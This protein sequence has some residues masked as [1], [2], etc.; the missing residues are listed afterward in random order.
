MFPTIAVELTKAKRDVEDYLARP[1]IDHRDGRSEDQ[2]ELQLEGIRG[3]YLKAVAANI[4]AEQRCAEALQQVQQSVADA[5]CNSNISLEAKSPS[6][7]QKHLQLVRLQKQHGGLVLL[8]DELEALKLS[9]VFWRIEAAVDQTTPDVF[10]E[11]VGSGGGQTSR[12]A[13]F[14]QNRVKA[15]EIALIQAEHEASRQAAMLEKLKS[16]SR[17]PSTYTPQQRM[18]ALSFTRSELTTW[19]EESLEKCQDAVDDSPS[20]EKVNDQG[21]GLDHAGIERKTDEEYDRYLEARK[22]L[23][24]AVAA[25]NSR[26]PE[27]RPE[28]E[29]LR[30]KNEQGDTVQQRKMES[31]HTLNFVEQNLLP[32]MQQHYMTQ[33]YLALAEEQLANETSSVLRVIERLSDESQLLEAF[34]MLAH[35]G[36]FQHASSVF[37]NKPSEK[38]VIQNEITQ[39]IEPWLFSAEAADIA[40]ASAINKQVNKGKEAIES[41]SRSLTELRLMVEANDD[42]SFER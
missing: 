1:A 26:L 24:S 6:L 18:S 20:R 30:R 21:A 19:L 7:L 25:L 37:G 9:R 10:S 36:R 4:A 40:A 29:V 39:R 13:D 22:R 23:L 28:V 15:L 5:N 3:E 33:K 14:V 38:P 8:K 27:H 41:V 31:G 2:R 16:Q 12:H 34:P 32:S 35:S 17:P 11:S 42:A